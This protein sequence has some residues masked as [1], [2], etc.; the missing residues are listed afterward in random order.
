M[1]RGI[2]LGIDIVN[3]G[4]KTTVLNMNANSS[5][6]IDGIYFKYGYVFYTD[7]FF[8]I[9]R[10]LLKTGVEDSKFLDRQLWT[11][12]PHK[13]LAILETNKT[14]ICY[15]TKRINRTGLNATSDYGIVKISEN[16]RY[17]DIVPL[18]SSVNEEKEGWNK[19]L[20]KRS[21]NENK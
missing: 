11:F 8:L 3:A 6:T 4:I 5:F 13:K 18:L 1:N 17:L 20:I 7:G 19:L 15:T 16:I 21:K 14:Y 10:K 12:G 9:Y 2:A